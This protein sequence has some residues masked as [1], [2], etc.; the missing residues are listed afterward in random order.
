MPAAE[1]GA[2]VVRDAKK[3]LDAANLLH[4]PVEAALRRMER[5]G[6]EVVTLEWL[7]IAEDERLNAV[8]ALVK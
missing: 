5:H 4:V 8:I 7:Q 6:V 3:L 2:A 1:E